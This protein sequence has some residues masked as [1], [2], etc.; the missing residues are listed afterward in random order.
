MAKLQITTTVDENSETLTSL[1]IETEKGR[2]W[3]AS[4]MGHDGD[5]QIK[6]EGSGG[7]YYFGSLAEVLEFLH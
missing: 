1:E 3:H 6:S 2:V 5:W 7:T 4:P